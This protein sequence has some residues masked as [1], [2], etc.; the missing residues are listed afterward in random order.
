MAQIVW[1]CASA[2]SLEVAAERLERYAVR[3]NLR[4]ERQDITD[5]ATI[6]AVL[7]GAAE[8]D[9]RESQSRSNG[10][11]YLRGAVAILRRA[12]GERGADDVYRDSSGVVMCSR[13]V[14][15]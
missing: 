6:R 7:D 2:E 12:T 3:H 13:G 14:R 9:W 4:L 11:R 10:R 15:D 8:R 1:P 5:V